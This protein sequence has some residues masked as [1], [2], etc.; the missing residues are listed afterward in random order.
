MATQ[1]AESFQ[2]RSIPGLGGRVSTPVKGV[3]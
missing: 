1:R 2:I 3:S